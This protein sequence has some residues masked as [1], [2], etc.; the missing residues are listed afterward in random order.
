MRSANLRALFP[1]L[2]ATLYCA[3][4]PLIAL[5]AADLEKPGSPLST[6]LGASGGS[7]RPQVRRAGRIG[8]GAGARGRREHQSQQHRGETQ[9][10]NYDQDTHCSLRIAP[11]RAPD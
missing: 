10:S 5:W 9:A 11:K 8:L 4:L 6:G 7:P 2:R 1:W 3:A